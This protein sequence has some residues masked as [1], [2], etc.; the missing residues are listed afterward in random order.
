VHTTH[1]GHIHG[2][3][4][5][6]SSS[7]YHIL[8]NRELKIHALAYPA[9]MAISFNIFLILLGPYLTGW[10]NG[11]AKNEMSLVTKSL[12]IFRARSLYCPCLI[13]QSLTNF[14]RCIWG[15]GI[16][17]FAECWCKIYGLCIWEH[18]ARWF[19]KE[20]TNSWEITSC[21]STL[22]KVVVTL[23][24]VVQSKDVHMQ[25]VVWVF[26]DKRKWTL[27]QCDGMIP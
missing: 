10:K 25:C 17:P 12:R 9:T 2:D 3:S 24:R 23:F 6:S 16:L 8:G 22:L 26:W 20:T 1:S 27:R 18:E 14:L 15:L 13:L 4:F 11:H 7:I 19:L 21:C 5:F